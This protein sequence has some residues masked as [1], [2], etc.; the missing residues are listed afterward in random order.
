MIDFYNY[1]ILIEDTLTIFD[2]SKRWV[3][4]LFDRA[5][6]YILTLFD[7]NN[8]IYVVVLEQDTFILA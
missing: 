8:T 3:I 2:N 1:L 6:R 4:R 5:R 7:N